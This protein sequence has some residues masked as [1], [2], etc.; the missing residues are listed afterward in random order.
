MSRRKT[1]LGNELPA[2]DPEAVVDDEAEKRSRATGKLLN[3]QLES[4]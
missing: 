1:L 2:F 3:I 4:K